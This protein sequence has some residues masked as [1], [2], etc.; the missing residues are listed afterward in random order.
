[1][2]SNLFKQWGFARIIRVVLA[3]LFAVWAFFDGEYWLLA[4]AA[5]LLMQ[6]FLGCSSCQN[7]S[8]ELPDKDIKTD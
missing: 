4:F 7:G 5:L 8:C 3:L 2:K 6:A 1:M